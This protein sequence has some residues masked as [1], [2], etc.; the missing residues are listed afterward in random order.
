M[1]AVDRDSEGTGRA[2]IFFRYAAM[3]NV[4][5]L[6]QHAYTIHRQQ[7][8][9]W[10]LDR[11]GLCTRSPPRGGTVIDLRKNRILLVETRG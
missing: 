3:T 9:T 2:P 11:A 7:D 8:L 1:S 5:T 10:N 6:M 4:P